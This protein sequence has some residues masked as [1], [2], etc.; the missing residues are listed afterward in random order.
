MSDPSNPT[1]ATMAYKPEDHG[2]VKKNDSAQAHT[3]VSMRLQEQ[4]VPIDTVV[5]GYEILSELGR[6]GMGVVYKARQVALNRTVALKMILAGKFADDTQLKRFQAEAE[7]LA[8]LQHP[9]IV[10]VFDVGSYNNNP[11]ITLEFVEGGNLSQKLNGKSQ[12]PKA[13]ARL[14]E[15]LARAI[16]SAHEVG[17][18]HRDLKPVNILLQRFVLGDA[19]HSSI[20]PGDSSKSKHSGSGS[21][22][23][24]GKRSIMANVT[25]EYGSPKVTDFG[26]AKQEKEAS[27]SGM[28]NA[29][30]IMGTPSYMSPE[31][32]LGD[33]ELI[34]PG[35]DVYALGAILYEMLTGRP[36][37]RADTPVNTLMEVIKAEVISPATLQAGLPK[38][39]ETITLKCLEKSPAK[40]YPS[41]LALAEDLR[42]YLENLPISARPIGRVERTIK[43][44]KRRPLLAG[45]YALIAGTV[46]LLALLG[47]W[48]YL[49]VSAR[50]LIAENATKAALKATAE[51]RQRLIRLAVANGT[52][53]ID[54]GDLLSG[55][56]WFTEA[57]KLDEENP[58]TEVLHRKRLAAV[59][60]RTPKLVNLW[61]QESAITSVV[62]SSDGKLLASGG[63][64]GMIYL[65]QLGEKESTLMPLENG[66]GIIGLR[67][68]PGGKE[69]LSLDEEGHCKRWTWEKQPRQEVVSAGA[70]HFEYTPDGQW[71]ITIG[72]LGG[73]LQ[74][75]RDTLEKLSIVIQSNGSVADMAIST[76]SKHLFIA[77]EDGTIRYWDMRNGSIVFPPLHYTGKPSRVDLH[78][79]GKL[80]AI[81]DEAGRTY[82]IHLTTGEAAL[83]SPWVQSGAISQVAFSPDG[84][85]IATASED[86]TVI[87]WNVADG[88]QY[89]PRLYHGSKIT[90]IQF[91][92]DSRWLATISEDNFARVFDISTGKQVVSPLRHNGSPLSFCFS[93]NARCILTA[94][95][96]HLLRHWSLPVPIDATVDG[97]E[98]ATLAKQLMASQARLVTSPNGKLVAN[99]GTEQPVRLRDSKSREPLTEALKI[100]GV[101]S[102]LAFSPDSKWAASGGADGMV[103]LWSTETGQPRWGRAGMHTSKVFAIDFHPKENILATGSDDNTIRLWNSESGELLFAPISHVGSV[104]FVRFSQDGS[105]LFSASNDGSTRVYDSQTGEAITPRLPAWDGQPWKDGLTANLTS[106][107]DLNNLTQ[108]LTGVAV[109]NQGG[110]RLL[111]SHEILDRYRKVMSKSEETK[112]ST[113]DEQWHEYHVEHSVKSKQWFAA[114]WHLERLIATGKSENLAYYRQR[115]AQVLAEQGNWKKVLDITTAALSLNPQDAELWLRQGQALGELKEWRK[116]IQCIG[117]AT[118]LRD[119][120]HWKEVMPAWVKLGQGDVAGYRKECERLLALPETS[121]ELSQAILRT[122]LLQPLAIEKGKLEKYAQGDERLRLCLSIRTEGTATE[123]L[124]TQLRKYEE[125]ANASVN[126]QLWRAV[127]Q[128]RQKQ[129]YQ[130]TITLAKQKRQASINPFTTES[131]LDEVTYEVLSRELEA[132]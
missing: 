45:M 99:F 49:A 88:K 82:M 90:Q 121:K 5:P 48:A 117:L 96:D 131:W 26:L 21:S 68:H 38:D 29:G 70:S 57:L 47:Y 108:A 120:P 64:D 53:F 77:N 116:S 7:A 83:P 35:S 60:A 16:H 41:A 127:L 6:G 25:V 128:K 30:S 46:L 132:K 62:I 66:S 39:L 78:P 103:Q 87:V 95:Q 43:W 79:E 20:S 91:T 8:K 12:D 1:E 98:S 113:D 105:L 34:G 84:Q 92:P 52:Q 44:V 102:A 85:R 10:Q 111:Q 27:S 112:L 19:R 71:I 106:L 58:A 17:I 110:Q 130:P 55:S 2:P 129:D 74:F 124:L 4:S 50:A 114:S 69:L 59:F 81:S 94:A 37:F 3:S 13:S 122:V 9:N 15:L 54:Q 28:T 104:Y 125:E 14:V 123:T 65:R 63:A 18:V 101:T 72:K 42:N 89:S 61:E 22:K 11:Y 33:V 100:S 32:A 31:Q 97:N 56:V 24:S 86:K 36:P 118:L 76:D 40:R 73:V 126:W 80:A 119:Q 115:L 67:M 51:T 107:A 109:D 93:A 75:K 23:H